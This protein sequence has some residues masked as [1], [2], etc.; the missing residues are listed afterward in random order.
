[1]IQEL[2]AQDVE[3]GFG[4][5]GPVVQAIETAVR[6]AVPS[7]GSATFEVTVEKSGKISIKVLEAAVNRAEWER[8]TDAIAVLVKNKHI[9][10]PER[11]LG[12]RIAV[13]VVASDHGAEIKPKGMFSGTGG[14]VAPGFGNPSGRDDA[15]MQQ[16]NVPHSSP[17][18]GGG[19]PMSSGGGHQSRLVSAHEVYEQRM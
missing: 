17:M 1:M 13:R 5:G 18:M 15:A 16:G 4:R 8:L 3:R 10:F 2:D 14:S 6:D 7:E 19:I 11:A 9:R 12:L